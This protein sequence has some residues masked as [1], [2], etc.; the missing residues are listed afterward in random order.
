MDAH[1]KAACGVSVRTVRRWVSDYYFSLVLLNP[2]E[3]EDDDL[4]TI[5]SSLRGKNEK[6]AS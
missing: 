1:N 6:N 3:I 5:F 4:D 2:N